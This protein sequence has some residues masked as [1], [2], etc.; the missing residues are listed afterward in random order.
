[1]YKLKSSLLQKAMLFNLISTEMK[2]AKVKS[3]F[4]EKV[5]S[6]LLVLNRND[7]HKNS[8]NF[9]QEYMIFKSEM[10]A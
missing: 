4:L 5:R 8:I 1:M 7:I 10:N 3:S 2:H 9:H 6:W